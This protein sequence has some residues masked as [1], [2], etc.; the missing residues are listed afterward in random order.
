MNPPPPAPPDHSLQRRLLI[1]SGYPL[2]MDDQ[3][4]DLPTGD[5][6]IEGS[7][8]ID[9]APSIPLAATWR[10][11]VIDATGMFVTPG[12]IDNHRHLWQSLIRGLS[13]NF[14]FGEYFAH[15]LEDLSGRFTPED[16][17]LGNLLSC[18]E[19]L[20][21][22]VT[23]VLDWSHALNTPAHAAA[24]LQALQGSGARATFAY[25]PPSIQWWHSDGA[26]A[27]ADVARLHAEHRSSDSLVSVAMAIRGPEFSPPARWR[28]DLELAR[29]LRIRVTMHAGVPGFHERAPSARLTARA[30]L[31]GPDL[32]FVHCNAMDTDD[33]AIVAQAGAHVSC[34]PEVEMQKGF[35]LSPLGSILAAGVRP[36]VSV[37]V[38]TAI[39]GDLLT[40]LRFLLQTQRAVD[41]RTA[42]EQT[43]T[44]LEVLPTTTRDVLPYVTSNAAASLGLADQIGTLTPGK[45][46]DLALY[47]A[48]DLNLFLAEPTA[49]L[50]Q[51][52]H[53]GNVHTVLVAGHVVKRDKQLVGLDLEHL[54]GKARHANRRLLRDGGRGGSGFRRRRLPAARAG[55]GAAPG[56]RSR[57]SGMVAAAVMALALAGCTSNGAEPSEPAQGSPPLQASTPAGDPV[58]EAE[59]A[60]LAVY[61]GMWQAYTEAG[62]PPEADPDGPGLGAHAASDALRVLV[63]GVTALRD[64]GLVTAGEV[65]LNPV[66]VELS[67][68]ESPARARIEDCADTSGSSRVRA[69]GEPFEDEPGGR[70]LVIATVEVTSGGVWKVVDFAVRRVG[71]C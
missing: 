20:D 5:I 28:A 69:D 10:G 6:L 66:V 71:S 18:Y 53:P 42:L 34:S 59:Q 8:I 49:G 43:G 7:Q 13:A 22:G 65:V 50:V 12:L 58:V 23:T 3:L 57:R 52:A 45:Q 25:G 48:S 67:P 68:E 55:S 54:R 29:D 11:E 14:T 9:V 36:T 1:H 17:Y 21:A 33:F 61:R 31:L 35:G 19:A 56:G 27:P 39:G 4:G 63:D 26:P 51:A 70:R 41:H 32:T 24:A 44:P 15:A 37:D 62:G 2:T 30:G 64:Q 40:Q 47:D 60:A 38:V 16:I 46:A